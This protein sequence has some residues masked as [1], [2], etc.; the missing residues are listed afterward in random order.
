MW[1]LP[2]V[3]MT[4]TFWVSL[5]W[6]MSPLSLNIAI[7]SLTRCNAAKRLVPVF[8]LWSADQIN[9]LEMSWTWTSST[10]NTWARR[11][12]TQITRVGIVLPLWSN[13]CILSMTSPACVL[14]KVSMMFTMSIAA[15][16]KDVTWNIVWTLK[17]SS[18]RREVEQYGD[19]TWV[20]FGSN[21]PFQGCGGILRW[22]STGL[23]DKI[24]S[25]ES[26]DLPDEI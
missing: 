21:V 8:S 22:E 25:W 24:L 3:I 10:C 1:F 23:P 16:A 4:I 17:L 5:K 12:T 26:T 18:Y 11:S 14:V 9:K 2:S 15:L 6:L 20:I 7:I 19:F 13:C